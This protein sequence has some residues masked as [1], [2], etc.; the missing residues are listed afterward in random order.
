[1]RA[2]SQRWATA[3][4]ARRPTRSKGSIFNAGVAIKWLRDTLGLID[5]AAET[6]R[7]ARRIDGDTGGVFVVPAF[8]GLG[9]PH[10][11]PDARGLVTGLTLDSN[12]DHVVTA[13]LKGVGFQ[14]ADLLAA[15][16]R[17]TA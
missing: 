10:W 15:A 8:T 9:A 4:R 13:T 5:S 17:P 1:M 3:W 16:G 6:E 7:A 2:C 14:T 12:R 11:R